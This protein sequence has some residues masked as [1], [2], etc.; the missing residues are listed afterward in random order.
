MRQKAYQSGTKTLDSALLL[1]QTT[2]ITA[3]EWVNK[4][5]KNQI[6]YNNFN[7]EW[8]FQLI[9]V[10]F[11]FSFKNLNSADGQNKK[12]ISSAII[13][14]WWTS[15]FGEKIPLLMCLFESL[16]QL[17]RNTYNIPKNS[18]VYSLWKNYFKKKF[19]QLLTCLIIQFQQI[20]FGSRLWF[21][22]FYFIFTRALIWISDIYKRDRRF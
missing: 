4:E 19:T 14:V 13:M 12:N 5:S 10:L 2:F 1:Y 7:D 21:L 17:Y 22:N 9:V 11:F 6:N 3:F 8:Q 16:H 18:L 20:W 15:F